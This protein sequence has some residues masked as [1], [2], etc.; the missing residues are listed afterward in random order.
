MAW[1][2]LFSFVPANAGR[3]KLLLLNIVRASCR[4]LNL[5]WIICRLIKLQPCLGWPPSVQSFPGQRPATGRHLFNFFWTSR[6]RFKLVRAI[7]HLRNL[8]R[9]GHQLLYLVRVSPRLLTRAGRRLFWS[10]F[11]TKMANDQLS[12]KALA[13]T[14]PL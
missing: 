1:R 12:T 2:H 10:N 4:L 3:A 11:R 7:R 6:R 13:K 9:A 14:T 5:V 8:V